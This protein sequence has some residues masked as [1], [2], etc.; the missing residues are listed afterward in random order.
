VPEYRHFGLF[1]LF[2]ITKLASFLQL[3]DF[4]AFSWEGVKFRGCLSQ[5]RDLFENSPND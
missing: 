1:K 2:R 5:R 4:N 3:V